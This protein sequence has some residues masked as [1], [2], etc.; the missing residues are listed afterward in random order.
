MKN[1]IL[2]SSL[3]FGILISSCGPSKRTMAYD[4]RID[5]LL[6]DNEA[7][8]KQLDDCNAQVKNLKEGNAAMQISY[9]A[10]ANDLKDLTAESKLTIADQAK[11]LKSLKDLIKMQTDAMNMLKNSVADALMNYTTDELNIDIKDGKVYVSLQEKL[12]FKSGSDVVEK[13]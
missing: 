10:V 3:I 5:K 13:R 8:V 4:A 6:K 1:L 9:S 11:R 12:L 7:T 2:L